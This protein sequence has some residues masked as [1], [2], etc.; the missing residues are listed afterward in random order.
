MQLGQSTTS[1]SWREC[2]L[3]KVKTSGSNAKSHRDV[4]NRPTVGAIAAL[5]ELMSDQ[6]PPVTPGP[7]LA[8]LALYQ[9]DVN[10][11]VSTQEFDVATPPGA[12]L[13]RAE[14]GPLPALGTTEAG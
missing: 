3:A 13:P 2:S 14:R 12:S 4:A 6:P 7:P 1:L 5:A 8:Q 11:V 10:N 9:Q